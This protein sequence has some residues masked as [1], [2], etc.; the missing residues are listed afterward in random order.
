MLFVYLYD[1]IR[2]STCIY[3]KRNAIN[4]ANNEIVNNRK[5]PWYTKISY[6]TGQIMQPYI[7]M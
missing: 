5:A 6:G 3:V 4:D 2:I 7:T 1:S